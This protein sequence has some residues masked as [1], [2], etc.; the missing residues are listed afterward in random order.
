MISV[1]TTCDSA[2]TPPRGS[3]KNGKVPGL[4]SHCSCRYHPALT[5][6]MSDP[7]AGAT[8]TLLKGAYLLF[9][10]QPKL[11]I[12]FPGCHRSIAIHHYPELFGCTRSGEGGRR[13]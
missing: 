9:A 10:L 1:V 4:S 13:R 3:L 11:V 7:A 8:W 2:C 5:F 6:S 12:T